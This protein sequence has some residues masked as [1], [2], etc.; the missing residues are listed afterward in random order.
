MWLRRSTP[1]LPLGWWA[2]V[3]ILCMPRSLYTANNSLEQNCSPLSERRLSGHPQR[4]MY[5]STRMSAAPSAVNSASE[6]AYMSAR[7][8]N[9]PVKSKM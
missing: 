2:L 7:W 6:T 4:S 9:L 1:P 8:L 5:L 3:A